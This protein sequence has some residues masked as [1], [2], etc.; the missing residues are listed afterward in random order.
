M[1]D[2][3]QLTASVELRELRDSLTG[4]ALPEPPPLEAI[5]ARGRARRR[6]R[7]SGVAGLFV[8]GAVAG[9]ALTLALAGGPGHAPV[10]ATIGTSAPLAIRTASYTLISDTSGTVKLTINPKKLF[11]A[12][13]L[14]SDLARFG[15][16]AKVTAGRFCTSDPEPAGL[17]QVVS[18]RTGRRQTITFDPRAIP[19][20]TE[21]SFGNFQLGFGQAAEVA[22]IDTHSFTCTSNPSTNWP[23]D[24]GRVGYYRLP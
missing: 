20:G 13:A 3:D 17:S 22:L 7:L 16:P 5:R 12:A 1:F 23:A 18:M 11:D 19:H 21:L 24:G 10:H 9:S 14:Q 8:T 6:R 2:N 4:V 15:I